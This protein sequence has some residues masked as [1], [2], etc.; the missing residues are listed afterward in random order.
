MQRQS[1]I[2]LLRIMAMLFIVAHHFVLYAFDIT[3][4]GFTF[5]SWVLHL[6]IMG[7]KLGV[8]IMMLLAGYFYEKSLTSKPIKIVSTYS[9]IWTYSVGTLIVLALLGVVALDFNSVMI[10]IMPVTF[11]HWWFGSAYIIFLFLQPYITK[12]LVALSEKEHKNLC[13]IITFFW[14]VIPRIFDQVLFLTDLAWIICVYILGVYLKRSKF[15]EARNWK[16]YSIISLVICFINL[17]LGMFGIIPIYYGMC[18]PLMVILAITLV[19]A[20]SNMSIKENKVIS[21]FASANLGVYLIH[22]SFYTRKVLWTEFFRV[23]DF[24]NS[25]YLVLYA[26]GIVVGVYVVC[27]LIDYIREQTVGKATIKVY[28]RVLRY[29]NLKKINFK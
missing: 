25:P 18:K 9:Q 7:G 17:C 2:D 24:V 10:S 21:F 20:F 26:I 13:L 14:I 5:N 29:I 11:E 27:S 1:N 28:N 19:T 22:D 15:Y 3:T 12:G 6:M 23:Q 4:L 8:N 16:H